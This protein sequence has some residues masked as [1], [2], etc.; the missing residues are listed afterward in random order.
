MEFKGNIFFNTSVWD[1]INSL[2][3]KSLRIFFF[4]PFSYYCGF[5]QLC[6]SKTLFLNI[7]QEWVLCYTQNILLDITSHFFLKTILKWSFHKFEEKNNETVFRKK[8]FSLFRGLQWSPPNTLKLVLAK[9]FIIICYAD[10]AQ[11]CVFK[12]EYI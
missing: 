9:C 3:A 11:I 10:L 6:T 2:L 4:L 12:L 7:H 8:S 5:L 1:R